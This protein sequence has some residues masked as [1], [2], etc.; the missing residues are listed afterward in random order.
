MTCK[1]AGSVRKVTGLFPDFFDPSEV[2]K[3]FLGD[4][5][6]AV[7]QE[8][9]FFALPWLDR[10]DGALQS[11]AARAGIDDERDETAKFLPN[12]RGRGRRIAI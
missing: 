9:R 1:L 8:Q 6:G 12:S 4:R 10:D 11:L 2:L 5:T 7:E 3:L